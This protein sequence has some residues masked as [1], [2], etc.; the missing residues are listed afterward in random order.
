M[1]QK[2]VLN[3]LCTQVPPF[4]QH[5]IP[6]TALPANGTSGNISYFNGGSRPFVLE[7]SHGWSSHEHLGGTFT[8]SYSADGPTDGHIDP[9]HQI[10]KPIYPRMCK[11]TIALCGLPTFATLGDVT[12]VVRCGRLLDVFLRSA[13]HIA[14]VSFVQEE[15]AVRFYE[16][17]RK[18][19][20]YINNKRVGNQYFC[21]HI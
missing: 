7:E 3:R 20:I 1:A 2:R 17:A 19:D 5:L 14:S 9:F 21:S 12:S 16:H 18:N 4:R 8:P 15:D 6:T 13:E 10:Q 11:R